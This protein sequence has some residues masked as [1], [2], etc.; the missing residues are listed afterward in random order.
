M[1]K[2]KEISLIKDTSELKKLIIENP[3]LPLVVLCNYELCADDSYSWWY[4]PSVKF[5]IGYIL[6]C[7]AEINPDHIYTDESELEDDL[8]NYLEDEEQYKNLSDTEFDKVVKEKLKE[9]EPYWKKVI[10]I[11]A[12]V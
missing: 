4:A 3:D 11:Y 10:A 8:V 5:E 1:I 12:D 9:Y 7:E 2:T 6:N